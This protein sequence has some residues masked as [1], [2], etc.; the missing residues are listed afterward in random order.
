MT[1]IMKKII[2]IP[3]FTILLLGSGFYYYYYVT[4]HII[5]SVE[6]NEFIITS[7]CKATEIFTFAPY[8]SVELNRT[9]LLTTKVNQGYDTLGDCLRSSVR[10]VQFLET[11]KQVQIQM[12]NG[13]I[14]KINLLL[15]SK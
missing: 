2:L 4:E 10:Q 9:E 12:Q 14:K 1:I 6:Q 3:I 7:K 13:Q 15:E 11:E 5:S 8:V